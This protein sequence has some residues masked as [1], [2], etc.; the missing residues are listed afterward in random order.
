LVAGFHSSTS[1]FYLVADPWRA[2]SVS[3]SFFAIATRPPGPSPS[4]QCINR[5]T[6]RLFQARSA[7][8]AGTDRPTPLTWMSARPHWAWPMLPSA[9]RLGR[10]TPLLSPASKQESGGPIATAIAGT[11]SST[12]GAALAAAL[13]LYQAPATATAVTCRG[14]ATS[15]VGAALAA[16]ASL[17]PYHVREV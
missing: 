6:D 10:G 14:T 8:S 17:A 15:T 1:R 5:P 2:V 13:A 4:A 16:C 7:E 12:V 3:Q 9:L 11:A